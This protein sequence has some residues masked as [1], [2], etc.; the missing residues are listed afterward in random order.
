MKLDALLT[1]S[2][3]AALKQGDRLIFKRVFD[4]YFNLIKY[5]VAQCGIRNEETI[6]IVQE[7]FFRFHR[8]IDS[9]HSQDSIKAWLIT[10]ARNLAI[11]H[12]RKTHRITQLDNVQALEAEDSI[13]E[14]LSRELEVALVGELLD[15]IAIETG[16]QTLVEFYR[17][18]LSAKQISEKNDEPISSVTNRLSRLRKKFSEYLKQHVEEL[19]ASTGL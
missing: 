5:V 19:R 2:D 1:D 8:N 17:L 6:D 16:D 12:L 13:L 14:N 3:F 11:D 4:Q 15:K 18:G 10:S 9:I 7:T